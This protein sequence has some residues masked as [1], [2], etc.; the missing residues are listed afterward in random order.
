MFPEQGEA[1]GNSREGAPASPTGSPTPKTNSKWMRFIKAD[2]HE[3]SDSD[4]S[5]DDEN[6][7]R[8]KIKVSN[9]FLCAT[10]KFHF[11]SEKS[12]QNDNRA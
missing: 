6:K 3:S 8:G 9:W 4:D 10:V 1:T 2:L 7:P 12:P 5:Q 11:I